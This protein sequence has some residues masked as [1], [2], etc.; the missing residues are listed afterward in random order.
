M[1]VSSEGQFVTGRTHP[2]MV[3][4][5]PRVVGDKLI[6]SAPEKP[7]IKID[8]NKLKDLP[9]SE[10]YVWQ[11]KVKTVDAG[12]EVADWLSHFILGEDI[13]LRLVYYPDTYP[14]RE[15]RP[16]NEKFYK[17]T[18]SDTVCT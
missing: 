4:I 6:L 12:D 16:K 14:T 2:K 7:T 5:S 15:I 8:F 13:G 10:T 11:Q 18:Q 17:I 1:V 3:L 9:S